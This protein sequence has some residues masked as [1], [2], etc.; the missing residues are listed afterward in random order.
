MV[1]RSEKEFREIFNANFEGGYRRGYLRGVEDFAEAI[2]KAKTE[3]ED[4]E[5]EHEEAIEYLHQTACLFYTTRHEQ[6][7]EA[8]R[9]ET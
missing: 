1:K 8:L 3:N 5:V 2:H 9:E 4:D 7:E 6:C